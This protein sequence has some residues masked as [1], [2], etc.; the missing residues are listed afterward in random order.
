[1]AICTLASMLTVRRAVA[2]EPATVF[3]GRHPRSRDTTLPACTVEPMNLDLQAG[4]SPETIERDVE[5]RTVK[6]PFDE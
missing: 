6:Q 5:L 4:Q 1:M 2:L 3:R